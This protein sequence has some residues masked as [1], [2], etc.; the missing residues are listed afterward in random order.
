MKKVLSITFCLLSAAAVASLAPG[1]TNGTNKSDMQTDMEKRIVEGRDDARTIVVAKVN[2][3]E[4]TMAQLIES[5][6]RLA[7]NRKGDPALENMETVKQEAM[8]RL[9]LQE[10]AYQQARAQKVTVDPKKI[11]FAIA[12]LK[13]NLGGQK[14]YKTY[15]KKQRLSEADLRAQVE[16][17]LSLETIYAREVL[18]KIEVPEEAVRKEYEKQKHRYVLPEKIRVV[19]VFFPNEKGKKA[20]LK[21][22][23][24]QLAVIQ[25]DGDQDPWKLVQD[26]SFIVRDL[27][28]KKERHANLYAASKE[29]KPGA[30]SSVIRE[31]DGLHII[32][33]EK[34]SPQKQLTF[35][36]SRKSLER[37]FKVPAQN[38]RIEEWEQELRKNAK[39]EIIPLENAEKKVANEAG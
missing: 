12:N 16:R 38:K 4:I 34:Y 15:L 20:S 10:L 11:D 17:R 21:N 23:K 18:D 24:K 37:K 35:E 7:A 27:E 14:A 6:N 30:L 29:L 31:P 28:V 26:G 22:A 13:A 33:L 2:G 19:D 5:M 32:K 1:C 25:A 36:E 8:D 39:I 3:T 9:I